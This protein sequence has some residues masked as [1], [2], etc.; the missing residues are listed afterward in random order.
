LALLSL[1]ANAHSEA[2]YVALLSEAQ[3]AKILVSRVGC[4]QLV[5]SLYPLV[6]NYFEEFLVGHELKLMFYKAHS[7]LIS[8]LFKDD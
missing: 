5:S 8:S 3:E 1:L 2:A 7:Q 4:L 6:I